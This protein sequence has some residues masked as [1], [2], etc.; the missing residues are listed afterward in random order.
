MT[1]VASV[2]KVCNWHILLVCSHTGLYFE[3]QLLQACNVGFA[4]IFTPIA[5]PFLPFLYNNETCRVKQCTTQL[6]AIY[7]KLFLRS[8]ITWIAFPFSL[9]LFC[10]ALQMAQELYL[11]CLRDVYKIRL[12]NILG[13]FSRS[14]RL[15]WAC[16]VRKFRF[17]RHVLAGVPAKRYRRC[18]FP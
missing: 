14:R 18:A 15:D 5:Q 6:E 7:G 1:Y 3:E 16:Q 8:S 11:R 13:Y 4:L 2:Q 12:R 10:L 9:C 17:G